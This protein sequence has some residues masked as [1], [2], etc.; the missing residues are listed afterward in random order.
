MELDLTRF[1]FN[2][3]A[4]GVSLTFQ[5]S[6][7][8]FC[9]RRAFMTPARSLKDDVIPPRGAWIPMLFPLKHHFNRV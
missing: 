1:S 2:V 5:R 8:T 3:F 6:A 9:L 7:R 4:F